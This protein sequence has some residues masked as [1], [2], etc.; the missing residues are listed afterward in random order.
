MAEYID[1]EIDRTHLEDHVRR[2]CRSNLKRPAK[3]CTKCPFLGPVIEIME[4]N[5]WK[6][7]REEMEKYIEQCRIF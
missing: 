5:K 4:E 3:I 6:Y 2:I 7:N 1:F